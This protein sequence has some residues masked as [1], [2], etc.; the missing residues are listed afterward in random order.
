[1]PRHLR[2]QAG[3]RAEEKHTSVRWPMGP[4]TRGSEPPVV[5]SSHQLRAGAKKTIFALIT[6]FLGLALVVYPYISNYFSEVEQNKVSSTQ[7]EVVSNAS[8]TDL[9]AQWDAAEQFNERIR[10]GLT[11]VSDPFDTGSE[12]PSDEEYNNTLNLAGDGVMGQIIIPSIGVNL[13]IYHGVG[14]DSLSSGVGHMPDTS[15]PIGGSSTHS[16]LAGHTGLPSSRIFDRLDELEVGD[17]FIIRVLGEDHAYRVTSTE[18]VLP[19]QTDSLTVQ[20]GKDLVTLVTCTP[21]GINTHRLL[22]HAERCD[23]PQEWLDMQ[24]TGQDSSTSTATSDSSMVWLTVLGVGCGLLVVLFALLVARRRRRSQQSSI[25][26]D[27]SASAKGGDMKH[28]R[29]RSRGKSH[30]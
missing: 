7:Q 21:Y 16:V 23:V 17:W 6:I 1:M 15:L 14:E 26:P 29:L 25:N 4:L 24:E 30:E 18:V 10:A 3:Q 8:R 20:D 9:S 12:S 2:D 27:D 11:H 13:P 19:D 22:V 28:H 5:S